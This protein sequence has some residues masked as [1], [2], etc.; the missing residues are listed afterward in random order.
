MKK[1][2]VLT[3]A[4]LIIIFAIQLHAQSNPKFLT[5]AEKSGFKST[6][7]HSDVL[8]FIKQLKKSSPYVKVETIAKS[9]EGKEIPLIIIGNPLP[10][11]PASLKN[12]KRIVVYYKANIHAGEVEG[13]EASLMLARDILAKQKPDYLDKVILLICPNYNPD[14][15]DKFA[16]IEVNRRGQNGPDNGTGIRYNGQ[17]LDLNRDAMKVEA[18][19][20]EGFIKNILNRW[21][22]DI[23]VDCHTTDGSLYEEAVSFCWAMNPNG[24]TEIRKYMETKFFP[25]VSK[26]LKEKYN[27]PNVAYGEYIDR[28]DVTKGWAAFSQEP[29]Y[30]VNYAGLRNRLS[31]LNENNVYADFKSRVLGCYNLLKSILDFAYENRD[32]IVKMVNDADS[33]TI[34]RGLNPAPSDSFAIEYKLG[35]IP[36]KIQIHSYDKL[37]TYKDEFGRTRQKRGGEPK[38]VELPYMADFSAKKSVRLP[39]GYLIT[40]RDPLAISLLNKHGIEYK[41]IKDS[42]TLPV[43]AYKITDLKPAQRSN[44]GHYPNQVKG[45]MAKTNRKF[46]AGT[47]FVPMAQKNANVAAYLL[48]AQA[49]DGMLFWNF[50]DRQV[51]S[52]WGRGYEYPVYRLIENPAS[53]SGKKFTLETFK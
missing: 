39:Y 4:A 8:D 13:K 10:K 38:L 34:A 44:Q 53:A 5:V 29:R 17:N 41:M 51:V 21:D 45:E 25:V 32:E 46:N 14:G 19:E 27:T 47:I 49:D 28:R 33:R 22:P 50:F 23:V 15:N 7:A 11:D 20:T 3:A 18:P 52:Q 26:T 37:E 24:S 30:V 36:H 35:F 9:V 43:E 12:D 6:S 40:T 31:I 48:E 42:V 1:Q 16:P 2:N